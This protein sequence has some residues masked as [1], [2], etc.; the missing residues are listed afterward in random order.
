MKAIYKED[1]EVI[2]KI[3]ERVYAVNNSWF[4]KN[5]MEFLL[6][7]YKQELININA[8]DVRVQDPD[9]LA[10]EYLEHITTLCKSFHEQRMRTLS[11]VAKMVKCV[12]I[13]MDI[14]L[15]QNLEEIV[16]QHKLNH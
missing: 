12:G 2:L 16:S 6:D 9:L 14:I 8:I 4:M 11:P 15:I 1:H 13:F 7:A 5:N 3:R 10:K